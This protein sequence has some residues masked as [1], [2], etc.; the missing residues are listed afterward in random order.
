MKHPIYGFFIIILITSCQTEKNYITPAVTSL[1]ES[2]YASAQIEPEEFYT[3]HAAVSGIVEQRYVEEGA[4][5]KKG[6]RLFAL[7]DDLSELEINRAELNYDLARTNYEGNA[8][9]LKELEDEILAAELKLTNDSINYFRQKRLWDQNIGSRSALD[10]KELNY[11]LAQRNLEILRNKYDRTK[12]ELNSQLKLAANQYKSSTRTNQDFWIESKI[13]GR[14]YELFKNE[15][16]AVT[17]QEPLA[18]VGSADQFVIAL[19]VDEVDIAR[20]QKGQKVI[21]TLEA[22]PGKVFEAGV[23]KIF[24]NMDVRSQT[25]RIEAAFFDPPQPLYPGLSGEANVIINQ[26]DSILTIPLNYL[27]DGNKVLTASGE[28][29]VQTGLKS[30]DQ[31][32]IISGIDVRTQIL[33]PN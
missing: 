1:T 28:I 20:V 27:T 10:Q 30:M 2:V 3:V 26:K 11:Q 5:I 6:E 12:K 7:S 18:T 9:L 22:F 32:E 33:N 15:G 21:L 14:V 8:T 17:I 23:Q 29:K 25:F 19:Q 31:V 24:P 16:E 13:D 4:F